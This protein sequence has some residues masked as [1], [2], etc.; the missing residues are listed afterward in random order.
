MSRTKKGR[1]DNG[2]GTVVALPNGKFHAYT[3]KQI[4]AR[5][6]RSPKFTG[7]TRREALDLLAAWVKNGGFEQLLSRDKALTLCDHLEAWFDSGKKRWAETTAELHGSTIRRWLKGHALMNEDLTAISKADIKQF[8]AS[9]PD[10][11]SESVRHRIYCLL[12]L[13]FEAAVQD[14]LILKNPCQN[15]GRPKKPEH[16]DVVALLPD[17]E[18]ALLRAVVAKPEWQ[19]LILFA[20]DSGCRQS[21]VLGLQW[22]SVDFDAGE[23]SISRTLHTVGGSTKLVAKTK[24]SNSRRRIRLSSATLDALQTRKVNATTA[25]VFPDSNGE[26][27]S[28]SRFYKRWRNLLK[29]AGLP[30]YHFHSCRHTMAT[31][32]LRQ[33]CYL[34]AVS[35]RLGHSKPSMTLNTYSSAIPEDQIPLAKA[36]DALARSVYSTNI[37]CSPNCSEGENAAA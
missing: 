7:R 26:P 31:R 36:F 1:R 32:L 5:T 20:L 10:T 35:R 27:F 12:H 34:T 15:S 8:F 9:L 21:E 11:A 29:S 33:G 24:T 6:Y 19:A 13:A 28:R 2:H 22:N 37:E 18:R 4:A 25:F 14:D 23:V 16:L 17:H 3:R 30:P